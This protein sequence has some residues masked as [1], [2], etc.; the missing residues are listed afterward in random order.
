MAREMLSDNHAAENSAK[1]AM[2]QLHA[3]YP[4]LSADA[5]FA[6]D[7]LKEASRRHATL[8]FELAH[9]VDGIRVKPK[10]HQWQEP[11]EMDVS[12]RSSADVHI[13]R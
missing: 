12:M 1:S 2:E 5:P 3:A 8:H 4:C 9:H 13:S 6:S 11:S 7:R 10:L